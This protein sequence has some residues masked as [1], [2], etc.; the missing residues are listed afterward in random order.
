MKHKPTISQYINSIRLYKAFP[1][2]IIC[3]LGLNINI[4]GSATLP[5]PSFAELIVNFDI[6]PGDTFYFEILF[7]KIELFH[8]LF[9]LHFEKFSFKYLTLHLF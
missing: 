5:D 8:N 4:N 7:R 6:V 9:T 2:L 3:R 1:I